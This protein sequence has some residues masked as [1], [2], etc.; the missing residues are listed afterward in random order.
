M[1][2]ESTRS[3]PTTNRNNTA[4]TLWQWVAHNSKPAELV[5]Y[6]LVVS[7]LL[8]WRGFEQPWQLQRLT[9][10]VHILTSLLLFSIFVVPFWLTHR[11]SLSCSTKRFLRLTGHM[12]EYCLI[13]LVVSGLYLLFFGNRGNLIGEVAYWAHLLP[14]VPIALVVVYHARRWSMLN[15]IAWVGVLLFALIAL[16]GSAFAAS[17]SGSLVAGDMGSKLFSAN[18]DA[19]T[20]SWI[21][22]E[23]G[24]RLGQ[25]TT[26]GDARRIALG[27]DGLLAVTDYTGG[28]VVFADWKKNRVLGSVH[29]GP[30]PFGIVY[31]PTNDIF[32]VTVFEGH[33]LA[34][35]HP[36]K[37]IV[38]EIETA[39]TPRGLAL[40]SDGRLLVTHALVGKVTIYDTNVT[41]TVVVSTIDLH[42]SQGDNELESQGLPRLLDDIAVSPDETEAW[43]PHLLW[44]FDHLFQ[45]Q[46]TIFPSVSLLDLTPGAERERVD[47]RKHLFRQIKLQDG[48]KTKLDG[49]AKDIVVSNPHDAAFSD[50]GDAV[51]VTMAASEDLMVFDLSQDNA[52][53]T[54]VLRHLPG[55]NPRGLVVS[56]DDLFVQN[57]MSLDLTR[58]RDGNA[59]SGARVQLVDEEFSALVAHDP[60]DPMLRRGKALFFTGNTDRYPKLPMAGDFWMSCQSCHV[61]GF[62]FTN[63]YLYRST[64]IDKYRYARIGHGNLSQMIAGNFVSDYIRI[65]QDTQGGMGHD[66]EGT[67]ELIDPDDPPGDAISMMA[68]LHEFVTSKDNLPLVST[69]LRLDDERETVH[70]SE[71]VNSAEC[72]QCHSDIF[73]QWSNSLHR[74]MGD[75]NPYYRVVEDVAAAAEG[76]E[77]RKWCMGCH[78]PQGLLSGLTKTENNGHMFEVGGTSLFEALD[79]REPDLDEGTGCLFCHRITKL[80]DA[81]GRKTG[82]NASFTINLKDRETFIFEDSPNAAL[83]WLGN[84]SINAKPEVHTKSYSQDFYSDSSLCGTCHTEFA[85]GSGSLIVDTYGEWARSPFND[86]DDPNKHRECI[87]CHMHA[88]I[89]RIGEDIP[90]ISTDRGR[91]KKNIVTHQFTGANY[92]LVG[93][94]DEKLKQMS[95]QLLQSAAELEAGLTG[96]GKLN[97][98]VKNVGAGHALPTGVADFRQV[99]LEVTVRDA[100]GKVVLDSGKMDQNGVVDSDARFFQKVFGDKRG[101]P[102][103]FIFW[104][105]EKMLKDTKIPAGGYRDE[106]F[107]LPTDTAFPVTADVKLMFRT[108]PQFVTDIV[109]ERYPDLTNPEAVVMNQLTVT[110]D[111]VP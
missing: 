30:R 17:E 79:R 43:L 89:K 59:K 81:A 31:D 101:K 74:L 111:G 21:D 23:S 22:R 106:A 78:H 102:V 61:D 24:E 55:Q 10:A 53:A 72:A 42:E 84:H 77:F 71:W 68:D 73:D 70:S 11:G 51:F 34:A 58:L 36:N 88:D 86:P 100:Q 91:M 65:I 2:S 8:L 90:G 52:P 99:W 60:I 33:R 37:G 38:Q 63:G 48:D 97:V 82:A 110:L 96:D 92:H 13:A 40:L 95:I 14:A 98:R 29:L 19:G 80:E 64:P 69:W 66:G 62:N 9:L 1:P 94:R 5:L 25:I 47:Q 3:E 32:W 83:H 87:D 12:I 15:S 104:R 45:F 26:G 18:F 107:D 93:L 46:S 44:N 6:F 39:E 76:E 50:D 7:G 108:Y 67:A 16:V 20:V 49:S 75:S 85:P 109:R 56:G 57:A 4:S 41:P 103:G 28:R 35:V 27:K 105:Y 54:Q